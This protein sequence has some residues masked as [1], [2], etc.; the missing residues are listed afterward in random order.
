MMLCL[1]AL[2]PAVAS[3]QTSYSIPVGGLS[4][5]FGA[6]LSAGV[7]KKL[8]KGLHLG[9]DGEV[10]FADNFSS[11]GR[12]QAGVGLTYKVNPYLKVGGGYIFIDKLNSSGEWTPRHRAYLDVRGSLRSGD[13]RFSL[14]ERLQLTCRNADGMNVYQSNPNALALKSR[15]KAEY[16]GFGSVS[17]YAYA[18]ARIALNDPACSAVWN[19]TS[20]SDY[21]FNGYTD[22]YLNRIRGAVGLSWKLS[23]QHALDFSVLGDYCYDKEVDTNASGTK[24]K[25]ISYERAFN[26]H[27]CVGYTFSF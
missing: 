21:S 8:A 4:T 17:P 16:K 24:L 18:E 26:T 1:L 7:D 19:G 10:R 12:W 23:K 2:L 27:I 13:W 6:R 9:V 15:L 11:L 14:K 25:S 3:G 22:T 20:F 5:D